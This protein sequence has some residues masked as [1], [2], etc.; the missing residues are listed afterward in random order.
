MFE[1]LDGR[2]GMLTRRV[3]VSRL[4][5]LMVTLGTLGCSTTPVPSSVSPTPKTLPFASLLLTYHGHSSDIFAV[6]WSPD[7][8]SIASA[9][10]DRTVRVW[11][12]RTAAT[13]I[14]Y[15]GHT[16]AIGAVAWSPD[17]Q[18]IASAGA[19][20]GDQSVQV[21]KKATGERI[22]TYLGHSNAVLT[23]AWSPDGKYLA[24]AG[25]DQRVHVW[26]TTTGK[27]VLTYQGH[28][29]EVHGLA[30]SPD[31]KYL[32]SASW[33]KTVQVWEALSGKPLLIYR[34]HTGR[35]SGVAWSPDGTTLASGS[36]D[37]TLQTWDAT[38]GK[39]LFTY[40]S[41]PK[42]L[43]PE[44][45]RTVAWSHSGKRLAGLTVDGECGIVEIWDTNRGDQSHIFRDSFSILDMAWSPDDT[46]IVSIS[47]ETLVKIWWT[48]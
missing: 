22:I 45:F 18:R 32:A 10:N 47:G 12:A 16:D 23:L 42:Q 36:W 29:D 30:W 4:M 6:A 17:G 26:S 14:I 9:G 11:D 19:G 1:D 5:S 21:W 43:R 44:L 28:R 25:I 31:G 37:R 15:R 24:S 48:A 7:G 46:R 13:N 2:K 38:S 33:D 20:P 35:V 27:T 8:K 40:Q 41:N 3:V 39:R 34:G